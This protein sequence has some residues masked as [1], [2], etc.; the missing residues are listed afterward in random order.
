MET[1]PK[2]N[3]PEPECEVTGVYY[4]VPRGTQW[5]RTTPLVTQ[6]SIEIDDE[7]APRT[8]LERGV[9]YTLIDEPLPE[10]PPSFVPLP[11]PPFVAPVET[12]LPS[13][14]G[15]L[16]RYPPSPMPYRREKE[17]TA[18]EAFWSAAPILLFGGLL[19]IGAL[20]NNK[21]LPYYA[22][23]NCSIGR[24]PVITHAKN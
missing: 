18:Q 8:P 15:P 2:R 4:L 19:V 1:D 23:G 7:L 5:P 21:P 10:P 14:S 3:P 11:S 24:A 9:T 20:F 12:T 13:V 6:P 22:A 16:R 17:T